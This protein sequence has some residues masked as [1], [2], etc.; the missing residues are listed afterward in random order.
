MNRK[1]A[2]ARRAFYKSLEK[3]KK[4]E[5][6]IVEHVKKKYPRAHIKDGKVKDYDIWVPETNTGIE[7]KSDEKSN[8]TNNIVIEVE[9][10]GKPSALSTTKADFWV[11]WDSKQYNWFKVDDIKKCIS[12][13]NLTTVSFTG[14]NDNNT[15]KAY[16]INTKLLF[17]YRTSVTKAMKD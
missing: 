11:I 4:H 8:W 10:A 7:V 3:G 12:E 1:V 16:L 14:K 13:N 9:F 15:K 6:E 5:K 17:K 2:K